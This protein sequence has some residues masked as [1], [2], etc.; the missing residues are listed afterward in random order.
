MPWGGTGFVGRHL[1]RRLI[2]RG[3]QVRVLTRRPELVRRLWSSDHVEPWPGDLTDAETLREFPVG[4]SVVYHLA[5]ENRDPR[6]LEIANVTGTKNL[7]EA[8]RNQALKKFVHLSTMSAM[9]SVSALNVDEM[10]PCHPKSAY[11]R[12][13]YAGE[14]TALVAARTLGVPVTVIRPTSVFREEPTHDDDRWALWFNTLLKGRSR[15][16]GTRDSMANYVYVGDVVAACLLVATSDKATGEIYIVSDSCPLRDFVGAAVEF[17]GVRMPGTLPAWVGYAGAVAFE[18]AG[19]LGRFS[20]PLTVSRI[21]A[22]TNRSIYSSHKLREELGY[23]P[24][25]GWREGL[26]RTVEWYKRNKLL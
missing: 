5:G 2:E 6:R 3:E 12:S 23:K 9:G 8:C 22:L 21:R 17:L 24:A 7:L 15:L 4:G 25:V 26:F 20:P 19:R 16:F 11:E 14:Q 10:T 18:M 1:V 13:K